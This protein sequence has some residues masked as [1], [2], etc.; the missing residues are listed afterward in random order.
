MKILLSAYACEPNKGSEPGV[1]W[2]WAIELVKLGHEVWVLTRAN[3]RNV[4]EAEL[5]KAEY[6]DKLHFI[7]YDLPDSIMKWKNIKGGIYLYYLLWQWFAFKAV[8][9]IHI[10]Q[11]F[12]LVHHVTFVSIRQPSFMGRLGIPFIFGPVAG[13]E[14]APFQLRKSFGIKGWIVD[15]ARDI[16]NCFIRLDPLMRQTFKSASFILVTSNQSKKL[17]PKI[18]HKKTKIQ[19]AIGISSDFKH[20]NL[21]IDNKYKSNRILFIGRFIFW[22]GLHIG[23]R[24]FEKYSKV[25]PDATFT[26]VGEGQEYYKLKK[27]TD[28]LNIS[29]KTIWINW[30]NQAQ[31]SDIYSKHDIFLFPSLHDSGG[32]V[33]L[34]AMIHGLPVVCLDIG[35]PGVIVDGTCGIKINT[36]YK[37]ASQIIDELAR[38]LFKLSDDKFL[39]KDLKTGTLNKSEQY[40]WPSVVKKVY[41]NISNNQVGQCES[42]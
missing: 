18:F 11:Q 24:A 41:E 2:N 3:N 22:K 17:I 40:Y 27:L 37:C 20:S 23:I 12:N 33:V 30:L 4:I 19:L 34:E 35:G 26:I 42:L 39:Y 6:S 16:A 10:K 5:Q 8:E 31:L 32:M 36:N 25:N 1:G 28:T 15:F 29:H 21:K 7:Y 38:A 9:K 14:T 13:G